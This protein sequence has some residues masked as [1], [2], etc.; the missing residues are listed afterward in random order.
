[1]KNRWLSILVVLALAVVGLTAN[2]ALAQTTGDIDGTVTDSNGAPLPG[3]SVTISSPALQGTRTAV[4]D[5]AG[6]F[7]FPALP[8]GTY[9]V[10]GALS[11]FTKSERRNVVVAIGRVASVP[12][13]M[14]VS[15]KEE[16]VVTGEAPVI[17]T[18]KTTIGVTGTSEQISRL[19]L[20]RNFTS[21][22]STAPGT[23]TD[24]SGGITFYGATGLENQ[25]IIDGVNTTGIKIGNVGKTLTNEFVQE[26]EVKTGGYEAEFG[27]ALGGTIN[28]VTKSGGNEFHGDLFGYYDSDNLAASNAHV[29][30]R[31]A[32]G[33]SQLILPKRMDFGADLGGYFVKD[34]LWFFGA[35]NG[36]RRD[37]DYIRNTSIYYTP[38]GGLDTSKGTG[39]FATS[40]GTDET[41]TTLYSGKLTFRLGEAHTLSASVFGDPGKFTG[42]QVTTIG[43]DSGVIWDT[44]NGGLDIAAKYDGIFG[45]SFL[46]SGQYSHHEEKNEN[47]SPFE[48]TL[49]NLQNRGGRTQIVS[50]G[51]TYFVDESYKR[52][53]FK[54]V[55]SFFAGAHEIKV[56]GEYEKLSS[57]F[58]EKYPGGARI[59]QFMTSAGAF[60]YAYQRYFAKVPLNCIAKYDA[61]GNLQTG[62]FG[63][64][65]NAAAANACAGYQTAA[66]V[67][68]PPTTKNLAIFAQDSW[69][70]LKNLTLNV[71]I[72][73]EEQN[74]LD[75]DGNSAIK[76]NGEWSPRVG[77][78]WDP[79]SNGR[80]KV[81]ASYGRYY[82]T[83]PQD[84]Q[85]RAL[86]NEYTVFAYNYTRDKVDPIT[87][88]AFFGYQ[89]IQGGELTQPDLKGMY[90]DEI[91][92]GIEYEVFK[93]WSFG[94]KGIY[95]K[96][97]RVI[98]DRCDLLDTRV[99]LASYVPPSALTTCALVNPGDDSP[100]QVIKDPT[101]PACQGP[102]GSTV[103]SGNCPS[104][105]PSRYYR[106]LE[107][108][109][110]HR[111]SNN[112]Y[113]LASYI[114]SQLN[115]NYSGNFSQTREN[116]Q[117]DPNINADFDYIDLTP[118]NYG[119]LRNNRKNQFK[120]TGTYAFNFGLVTSINAVYADGRPMSVRGYARPGYSQERYYMARGSFDTLPSTYN[121]DLHLEYGFRLGAVTITPL[122]DVFNLTDFQGVTSR[123]EVFCTSTG[124]CNAVLASTGKQRKEGPYTTA[125]S[126][127]PNFNRD[128]AWQNPRLLRLGLR[129]SF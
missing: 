43:P 69:K 29:D 86:G 124:T 98:E 96:L 99:G 125:N 58:S 3:A 108:T 37:Q 14:S 83:I 55:G 1:M 24:N 27:R 105:N 90:Q 112:F 47:S 16:V 102:A 34:R 23:G 31:T 17:D 60:N 33:Q 26:V 123:D 111:F 40:S 46:L 84:I 126:S 13:T 128:I 110:T 6:R 97:G 42:R 93:G 8:G 65:A 25:Y 41:R 50:G 38:T 89:T 63:P 49:S 22:A 129:V 113:L 59:F 81:Y 57:S 76:I 127:N 7:R 52:D 118:N 64:P 104:I 19:P 78:I 39:G 116:G 18:A 71:G 92:G 66:S 21:V 115:G 11:G 74:L 15:V 30:D 51:P 101:N 106:G 36:V 10:T 79:M 68:N 2:V 70:I 61:S 75:A 88:Y 4:T 56:G 62:N 28:V 73:Y 54:L 80:S 103:L 35:V 12:L 122:L 48:N 20:A 77:I 107:L 5:A 53:D 87:D 121:I 72:R 32:V 100:L 67:D 91:I 94:V 117:S 85:T 44:E 114:Y 45:T 9:T 109:A 82:S 120:L 119:L 95:K